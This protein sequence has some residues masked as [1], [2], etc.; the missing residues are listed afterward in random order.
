ML[1][2]VSYST[3][4]F[5]LLLIFLSPRIFL[6]LL[7]V[8]AIICIILE[9][10]VILRFLGSPQYLRLRFGTWCLSSSI[11]SIAV[12]FGLCFIEPI[13]TWPLGQFIRLCLYRL[14]FPHLVC[15]T[16]IGI[17]VLN[18]PNLWAAMSTWILQNKSM[19][20]VQQSETESYDR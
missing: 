17:L 4:F 20:K 5:L 3:I 16:V 14:H 8:I 2:S 13:Q 10:L 11:F 15:I 12:Y 19:M 1:F 9:N 18:G 7:A 6:I